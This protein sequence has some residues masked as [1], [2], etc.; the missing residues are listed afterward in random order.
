MMEDLT[1]RSC[2]STW[3]LIKHSL[4]RLRCAVDLN[5]PESMFHG[6][7]TYCIEAKSKNRGAA[8]A[9]KCHGTT[10]APKQ[11]EISSS[12]AGVSPICEIHSHIVLDMIMAQVFVRRSTVDLFCQE[13]FFLSINVFVHN[14]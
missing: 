10:T 1:S 7:S 9:K 14:D 4:S 5:P 2:K 3:E 11:V 13:T 8:S 6:L 12:E